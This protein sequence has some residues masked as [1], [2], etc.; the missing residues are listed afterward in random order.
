MIQ[1]NDIVMFTILIKIIRPYSIIYVTL[2]FLIQPAALHDELA[3]VSSSKW[4]AHKQDIITEVFLAENIVDLQRI[5]EL[6]KKINEIYGLNMNLKKTKF[7]IISKNP[8]IN[9][10]MRIQNKI[11][12][13]VKCV[14]LCILVRE[15]SKR[16]ILQKKFDAELEQSKVGTLYISAFQCFIGCWCAF[17]ITSCLR[18]L[19]MLD[20]CVS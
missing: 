14:Y 4:K 11:I 2:K 13:R 16:T 9:I 20:F 3:G 8:N 7:M 18:H 19:L 6:V 1:V 10:E 15:L 12:E 17:A 5:F